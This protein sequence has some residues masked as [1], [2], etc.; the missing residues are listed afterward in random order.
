MTD[1]RK[2]FFRP[3][4][5]QQ[6]SCSGL[7]VLETVAEGYW[8][9]RFR[10]RI[11]VPVDVVQSMTQQQVRQVRLAEPPAEPVQ[12]N[13]ETP[14]WLCT[15]VQMQKQPE[16]LALTLTGHTSRKAQIPLADPHL[17]TVLDILRN[18][19]SKA[20][21]DL[22]VFPDWLGVEKSAIVRQG[23]GVTLN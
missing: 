15:T 20:S 17:R 10:F 2:C 8:S 1:A 22:R 19:Y 6:P 3:L 21:W 9:G 16:G 7:E 12:A 13:L 11:A 14:R 18:S 5:S 23:V 4:P